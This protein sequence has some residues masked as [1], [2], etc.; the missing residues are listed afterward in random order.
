[1][2]P[3]LAMAAACAKGITRLSGL[4]ELRVK[5]SDRLAAVAKGL[6]DC[7]VQVEVGAQSLTIHGAG[8]PPPGG[9]HIETHLDHRIAM[10][11]AVLGGA[12]RQAVTIDDSRPVATSFPGFVDLMNGL[13]ASIEPADPVAL[14]ARD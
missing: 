14:L 4:E 3:V 8:G 13:G 11:F 12:A 9:G 2:I 5:E 6:A 1:E 7:G 10:A